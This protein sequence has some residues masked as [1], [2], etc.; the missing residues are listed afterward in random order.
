MPIYPYSCTECTTDVEVFVRNRKDHKPPKCC[1]EPMT[2]VLT[3]AAFSFTIGGFS[4]SS[5]KRTSGDGGAR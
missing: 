4:A 3:T 1:G 5:T 2:R